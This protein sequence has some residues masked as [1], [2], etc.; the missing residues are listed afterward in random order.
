M[1]EEKGKLLTLKK[2]PEYL[3]LNGHTVYRM[4]RKEKIST[5]KIE[6]GRDILTGHKNCQITE[7]STRVST[8]NLLVIK[9]PL[10]TI[11]Y[12]E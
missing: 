9:N 12:E 3:R 5:V 10:D 4:A 11:L 7:I 8:K 2:V 6:F 1:L